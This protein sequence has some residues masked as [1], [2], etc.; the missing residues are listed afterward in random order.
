MQQPDTRFCF[1]HHNTGN[2]PKPHSSTGLTWFRVLNPGH[3]YCGRQRFALS[4]SRRKAF[5]F[6]ECF[7]VELA[8]LSGTTCS[9]CFW[10]RS[11]HVAVILLLRG[12]LY[13]GFG[14]F[15]IRSL[16]CCALL[17]RC[18]PS[19]GWSCKSSTAAWADRR[20]T[21][22][23]HSYAIRYVTG[24]AELRAFQFIGHSSSGFFRLAARAVPAN[25][26]GYVVASVLAVYAH[27]YAS[28]ADRGSCCRCE[29]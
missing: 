10:A 15:F 18:L 21:E 29:D 20:G 22:D 4:I 24:S 8:R 19:S 25:H 28:L 12:C 7:S 26:R 9:A 13:F 14:P 5:W 16:P 11:Q 3:P 23:C 2:H 17:P 27:F 1:F 6:D